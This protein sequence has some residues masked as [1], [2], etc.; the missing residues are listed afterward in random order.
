MWHW[1]WVYDCLSVDDENIRMMA[2]SCLG[3]LLNLTRGEKRLL[4]RRFLNADNVT[5][6]EF[7]E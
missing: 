2:V 6:L 4:G 1:N 5:D 3:T 7:L